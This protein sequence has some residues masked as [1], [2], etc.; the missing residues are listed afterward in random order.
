[1]TIKLIVYGIVDDQP[2]L[3]FWHATRNEHALFYFASAGAVALTIHTAPRRWLL[4]ILGII[5]FVSLASIGGDIVVSITPASR[6]N[7]AMS[8]LLIGVA[9]L[10]AVMLR[11]SWA[12]KNG[13]K[14]IA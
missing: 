7:S 14:E 1:L 10:I 3:L 5:T 13:E 11:L 8:W 6:W 2:H 12:E 9:N 4:W